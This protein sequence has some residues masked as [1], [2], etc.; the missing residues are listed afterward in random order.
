[1]ARGP[2]SVKIKEGFFAMPDVRE[3][4]EF[5]SATVCLSPGYSLHDWQMT[6]IQSL[7]L[8]DRGSVGMFTPSLM[9][10]NCRKI[11]ISDILEI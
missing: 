3:F 11:A 2:G 8:C 1:M 6:A 7:C 5:R 9:R 10:F 4:G